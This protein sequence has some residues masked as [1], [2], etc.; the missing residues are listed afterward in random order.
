[1]FNLFYPLISN[2]VFELIDYKSERF[3]NEGKLL[4]MY[5]FSSK[6]NEG[7]VAEFNKFFD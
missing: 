7:I 1:M 6:K 5:V 4:K 3:K 2:Q